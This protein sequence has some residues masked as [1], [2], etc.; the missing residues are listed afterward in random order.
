MQQMNSRRLEA[1]RANGNKI[2]G[3]PPNDSEA[4]SNYRKNQDP[5]KSELASQ[6]GGSFVG[7]SDPILDMREA[8]IQMNSNLHLVPSRWERSGWR[9]VQ[10]DPADTQFFRNP[11]R[12]NNFGVESQRKRH[13]SSGM[14]GTFYKS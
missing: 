11:N 6:P 14:H 9:Y 10:K 5:R 8:E 7:T 4:A 12:V 13:A 2:I 1:I 3:Q